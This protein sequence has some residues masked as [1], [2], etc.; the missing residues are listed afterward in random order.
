[1]GSTFFLHS[2]RHGPRFSFMDLVAMSHDIALSWSWSTIFQ[3]RV[4]HPRLPLKLHSSCNILESCTK[5]VNKKLNYTSLINLP[6]S[7]T[8]TTTISPSHV[9]SARP[10]VVI[11]IKA[12]SS[13]TSPSAVVAANPNTPTTIPLL[14]LKPPLRQQS[15]IQ[16]LI[17]AVKVPASHSPPKR[18]PYNNL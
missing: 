6:S 4:L 3:C 14:K 12:A 11:G 17:P 15:T 18:K 8:T 7:P 2:R 13:A 5:T 16:I 9:T 1:M 10:V